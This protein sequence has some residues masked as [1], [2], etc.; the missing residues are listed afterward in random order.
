MSIITLLRP[1]GQAELDLIAES[2]WKE[3]PPRLEWQPIF[4]PVLNEEYATRIAR[5]WNTKDAAGGNVGYVLRFE[6]DAA[7]ATQF[8]VRTVGG[9]QCQELWV[10]ADQLAEFNAHIVDEIEV[11]SEWLPEA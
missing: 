9:S 6:V 4:Y 7:F 11:V 5:E 2:G 10:P 8:P 1:V 3:F